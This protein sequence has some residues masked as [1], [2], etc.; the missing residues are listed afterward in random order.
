MKKKIVGVFALAI[1]FIGL[2]AIAVFI[3]REKSLELHF[4]TESSRSQLDLMGDLLQND[5]EKM[6]GQI[7]QVATLMESGQAEEAQKN[8][9]VFLGVA[10]L[11]IETTEFLWKIQTPRRAE[12]ASGDE[13]ASPWIQKLR[14]FKKDDSELKFF[15]MQSP[16]GDVRSAI[17]IQAN[18]RDRR[19]GQVN[20]VRLIGLRAQ[21]L[22]QDYIDKLKVQG[23]HTFLTTQT[24]LT[25]AHSVSEYVGNSMQ[26]DRTYEQIRTQK[27][28]FGTVV[29]QDVRGHDIFSFYVKLPVGQLTLVSQWRKEL[30]LATDWTF[31]GQVLFFLMAFCLLMG[32]LAQYFLQLYKKE[33]LHQGVI[34]EMVNQEPLAT[35]VDDDALIFKDPSEELSKEDDEFVSIPPNQVAATTSSRSSSIAIPATGGGVSP[36]LASMPLPAAMATPPFASTETAMPSLSPASVRE[37]LP[38]PSRPPLLFTT[39]LVKPE[40][41]EPQ[42]SMTILDKVVGALRAPLLS[43]LGHVQMARLNPLGGALQSIETEVRSAKDMLDRV[44]QFSGQSHVPSVTVPLHEIV[45]S[46]LR[47]VEGAVLRNHIKIIREI[48]AD[49]ALKC[50]V[51]DF[52]TA[53]IAL[54]TNAIEAM[55]NSLRKNLFIRAN[56]VNHTMTLEIEDSGEGM[57]SENLNKILDPFFTTRS[58]F[59]HTGLGLSAVSGILR[60]H[61]GQ[62]QVK[63]KLGHGTTVM[64]QLPLSQ[65]IVQPLAHCLI[66]KTI[67]TEAPTPMAS[68]MASSTV[69]PFKEKSLS[70]EMPIAENEVFKSLNLFDEED[71]NG[72]FQFGRL[73]FT[74][75]AESVSKDNSALSPGELAAQ[76][77]MQEILKSSST[78]NTPVVIDTPTPSKPSSKKLKKKEE[79]LS[80][81]KVQ[82]PRPE[83]K[84]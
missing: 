68:S 39:S 48:P 1:L 52:K 6:K 20:K 82:I 22:F 13:W 10:A 65:E 18:V 81:F 32:A 29:T 19:S 63:S 28:I 80:K 41:R 70:D 11:N 38:L 12:S 7:A 55:E 67:K 49:L 71:S 33:L 25:L 75:E 51:D 74:E 3:Q 73:E 35:G 31:Y 5:L 24:G 79:T 17:S 83:E 77:V 40:I 61:L 72:D 59:D 57:A 69:S 78:A 23:V 2:L 56:R 84:L 60:Q 16:Q 36:S 27:N 37:T 58:T 54:F 4:L 21:A 43:V 66:P 53:L 42:V 15:V 34:K 8:L 44:G 50:D 14:E 62:L 30:W 26:G 64:I 46:S 76:E 47:S 9:G 45:E